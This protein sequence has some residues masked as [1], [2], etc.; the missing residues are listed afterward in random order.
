MYTLHLLYKITIV[1]LFP[2]SSD[3]ERESLVSYM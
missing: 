2:G 1:A 3:L